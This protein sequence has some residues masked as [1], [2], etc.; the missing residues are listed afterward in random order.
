MD[1]FPD[2]LRE[3][4]HKHWEQF[5][6]QHP[7][8]PDLFGIVFFM[9]WLISFCGNSVVIMVFLM[10]KELRTPVRVN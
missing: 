5:P 10:T 2:D 6:P 7:L 8:I 1:N 4:V 3:V 9:L